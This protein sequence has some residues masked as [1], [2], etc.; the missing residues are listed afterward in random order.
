MFK[1]LILLCV[2]F[3]TLSS[4]AIDKGRIRLDPDMNRI[5]FNPLA[6][7]GRSSMPQALAAAAARDSNVYQEK[8]ADKLSAEVHEKD[9]QKTAEIKKIL[10]KK[11]NYSDPDPELQKE[12]EKLCKLTGIDQNEVVLLQNNN[13]DSEAIDTSIAFPVWQSIK[14]WPSYACSKKVIVL[15]GKMIAKN[16]GLYGENGIQASLFTLY[17][18]FGH[19]YNRDTE[20][21]SVL[22]LT[23]LRRAFSLLC[24]SILSKASPEGF[25]RVHDN[26]LLFTALNYY[27]GEMF[28]TQIIKEKLADQFAIEELIKQK[29]ILAVVYWFLYNTSKDLEQ[30]NIGLSTLG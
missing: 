11:Y 1:K 25:K 10:K 20:I 13:H 22:S 5:A 6:P 12:F 4:V 29:N 8:P 28:N 24:L 30:I 26:I 23:F 7:Y 16:K 27:C 21:A 2:G 9:R 3:I 18:E 17:H 19:V 15:D 14:M